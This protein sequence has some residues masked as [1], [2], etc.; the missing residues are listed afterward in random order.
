MASAIQY[1]DG[2]GRGFNKSTAAN[3]SD[4]WGHGT[5]DRPDW[6]GSANCGRNGIIGDDPAARVR[7]MF[8]GNG[9]DHEMATVV[10]ERC[11]VTA[12]CADAVATTPIVF[13]KRFG[14]WAGQTGAVR[15][16]PRKKAS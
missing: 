1:E 15:R 14:I 8:P 11:P 12:E 7:R 3:T 5:F 4:L 2:P 6:H 9:N 16:G 10:C 13:G